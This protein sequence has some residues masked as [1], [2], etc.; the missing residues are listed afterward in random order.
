MC[1]G[2]WLEI[3][4]GAGVRCTEKQYFEIIEKKTASLFAFC[5]R[6]GGMLR[7][8]LSAELAALE[9]F[10]RSFGLAY[11]LLDDSEDLSAD[12]SGAVRRALLRRG[13]ERYCRRRAKM[14]ATDAR[15]ALGR[16]P[17]GVASGLGSLLAAVLEGAG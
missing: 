15:R 7:R 10:G 2:Q 9:E 12:R 8:A 4:V 13:G 6:T 1:E 5:A 11:Q 17:P 3:K 16:V 14:A